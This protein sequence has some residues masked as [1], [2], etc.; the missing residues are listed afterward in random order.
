MSAA[1]K[2]IDQYGH[3]VKVEAGVVKLSNSLPDQIREQFKENRL[4]IIS[5]L[6]QPQTTVSYTNGV[7]TIHDQE[8]YNSYFDVHDYSCPATGDPG[9]K[10]PQQK[11]I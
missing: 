3:A 11:G 6:T 9:R 2:L 4:E 5:L 1:R 10:T 7:R 8:T